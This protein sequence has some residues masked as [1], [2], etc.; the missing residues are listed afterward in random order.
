MVFKK[1]TKKVL[2]RLPALPVPI[3]AGSYF[4]LNQAKEKAYWLGKKVEKLENQLEFARNNVPIISGVSRGL[5][6][7]Q[8]IVDSLRQVEDRQERLIARSFVQALYDSPEDKDLGAISIGVLLS[9]FSLHEAAHHYF[10]EANATMAKSLAPFE[11]FSSFVAVDPE[12]GLSDLEAYLSQNRAEISPEDRI[13]LLKVLAKYRHV[14]A[15]RQEADLLIAD[16]ESYSHLS[17]KS[18]TLVKWFRKQLNHEDAECVDIP[19]AINFAVMDYKQLDKSRTSRNRGDYVQTLAALSNLLRFKGI[20]FV[21]ETKLSNYLNGLKTNVHADRQLD[22]ETIKVQPVVIDRDFSSSRSYPK[23]TWLISNGWFMHRNYQG[24]IDFPYPKTILPLMISFHI[25]DPD[26]LTPEVVTELKR[27]EPIG[28]R[29]WTTLYRLRDFGIKAFFSGCVTTTV[30]QILPPANPTSSKSLAVVESRIDEYK[31]KDWEIEKFIQVGEH[32][33]DFDLV[34]GIEDARQMLIEYV[35]FAK[36]AT[37]RL[38]CYLPARS[39][40]LPV[41]FRPKNLSDVRFEGL[42]DLDDKAF[43]KI[44]HGI[45]AKLEI[46]L[47]AILA[48]ESEESVRALWKE[49]CQE[50]VEFAEKYASTYNLNTDSKIN[51]E[52][53]VASLSNAKTEI[54]H[55]PRG[56]KAVDVA[57]A[58]DQNLEDMIPVVLQSLVEHSDRE[59][60]AHVLTR[61]LGDEFRQRMGKLFPKINFSFYSFDDVHYGDDLA[62]LSHISVSTMDRLFL[63]EILK[64]LDKVLYLDIDILIQAD[65]GELYDIE[66]GQNVFAGKRTKLKTW[67]SMIRIVTRASLRFEPTKAWEIRRRLHDQANLTGRTFNAGILLLNLKLMRDES[68]TAKHLYL[69][70]DCRMNDQDVLNIYSNDRVV[71]IGSDWNHVPSQDF[72]LNPKIIHWA[73]PAKPWNKEYVLLQP[74]FRAVEARVQA[75]LAQ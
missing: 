26:V 44:R 23:N 1:L 34:E 20:Q 60:N 17:E 45:E 22:S 29:D 16:K 25:Q 40:G 43:N 69:V 30:G 63:P 37:S 2:K 9:R 66:L 28:C 56:A 55:N 47:K 72:H 14:E 32:V 73:G 6:L 12:R 75:K 3:K 31:Y 58:L 21:G 53:A 33:Q 41:D 61:G 48:G 59:I 24:P 19:G 50:E 62:L 7:N 46:T 52:E 27:I 13:S 68:F 8:A 11:Y 36:V 71:E 64:T 67:A 35:P 18:Q 51:V 39:M 49:I 5:S 15:L 74:R 70:E 10:S 4:S 38:H 65:V 54:G 57:L 42:I